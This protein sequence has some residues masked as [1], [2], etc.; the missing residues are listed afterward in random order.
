MWQVKGQDS[1]LA[2]L[3]H[4]LKEHA[5]AHAYLLVGP[6]HIGK[7]TLALDLACALNC[8]DP[9]PPCGECRSCH[10]IAKGKHADV[11]TL[12]LHAGTEI[13]ID[14]IRSLQHLA[15]LPPYEGSRKVL[16]IEDAECMS[17]EAANSL[18]KILEEPPPHLVWLL[19][20]A[21]EARLLPTVVSRC[22]RLE[23]R[24]LARAQ[25]ESILTADYGVQPDRAEF[26]A[27]LSNGCLGWALSAMSDDGLLD[28]RSREIDSLN[29]LLTA[30]LDQRFAFAKE[31]AAQFT[32]NRRAAMETMTTWL[33]WWR[34]LLLVAGE[35]KSAIISVDYEQVLQ[36]EAKGLGLA[37]IRDAIAGLY[38]A[39]EE[40][41]RN[42]SP[43]LVLDA[44]MLDMPRLKASNDRHT[45]A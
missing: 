4:S 19:L 30:G 16:I 23:L 12:D 7:R 21:E 15:H 35:C 44:F 27:R 9:E 25:I 22:Q 13:G 8:N 10:R 14:D 33:A 42:V 38:L 32:Q 43:R 1:T 6:P 39:K 3:D 41:S 31:L 2:L 20:A 17:T 11:I 5:V 45:R 26:L 28:R 36:G 24:P 34:D 40:I 18:L 29:S 37:R